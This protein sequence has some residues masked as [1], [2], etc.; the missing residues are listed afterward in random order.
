M[1]CPQ[2]N[3]DLYSQP[4]TVFKR[5]INVFKKSLNFFSL[6]SHDP[7]NGLLRK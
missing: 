5:P 4:P 2:L 3:V 1:L 6:I 7:L